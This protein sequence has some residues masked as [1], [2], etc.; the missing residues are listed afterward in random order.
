MT[1]LLTL[2]ARELTC[3]PTAPDTFAHTFDGPGAG[4]A[5]IT[6]DSEEH[7]R[8]LDLALTLLSTLGTV[9]ALYPDRGCWDELT[10]RDDVDPGRTH[11]VGENRLHV[12][13]VDR[14]RTPRLIALYCVRSDP[15]GGG[16]SA[17]SDLHRAAADLDQTD[18][19]LLRRAVFSYFTDH[20]VHGVGEGLARF[21]VLPERIDNSAPI[22]FTSKMHPHLERGELV[23]TGEPKAVAA[24]F[25]RLV[26]AVEARRMTV[27]LQPGQLLVFDQWRYA[28]G[29]MPL[30][31]GQSDLPPGQR[32]LLKQAYG[33]RSEP[34]GAAR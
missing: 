1:D 7:D 17:L 32:R 30:G 23:D 10:V 27:R 8:N 18:R 6:F 26:A 4:R 2:D 24:A 25:G 34:D 31:P 14:D 20:G 11:G 33:R 9:L 5:V 28:H 21:A 29:R 16:A 19:E 15:A 13:L 3:G 22:R 12:D